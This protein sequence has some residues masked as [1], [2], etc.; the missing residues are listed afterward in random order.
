MFF[1]FFCFFFFVFFFFSFFLLQGYLQST[2]KESLF[3]VVVALD[4][5]GARRN[6]SWHSL[7]TTFGERITSRL[8][9]VH[10]IVLYGRPIVLA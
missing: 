9:R 3:D 7:G 1:F 4:L 8:I 10:H 2:S 5:T 6:S